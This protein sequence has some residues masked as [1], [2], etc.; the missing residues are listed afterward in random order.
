MILIYYVREQ[1]EKV[2][3]VAYNL[4]AATCGRK[5][6][7]AWPHTELDPQTPLHKTCAAKVGLDCG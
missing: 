2:W 6:K 7:T 3:H 5:P 1:N 4:G